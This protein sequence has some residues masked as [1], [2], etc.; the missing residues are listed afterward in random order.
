M[1]RPRHLHLSADFSRIG[2]AVRMAEEARGRYVHLDVMDGHFVPNLTLGPQA[3]S[4]IRK[5]TR[6]PIDVHLMV[7]TPAFS[8]LSS[9]GGADWLRSMSRPRSHLHRDIP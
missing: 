8:S 3:G 6:L 4:S 2:E 7:E 1:I 9:R 5:I